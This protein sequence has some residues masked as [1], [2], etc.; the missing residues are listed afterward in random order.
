MD[1][2]LS[3]TRLD[4]LEHRKAVI[5]GLERLGLRIGRMEIF[6]ARPKE[7]VATCLEEIASC[8]LFVGI[9][10]HRYGYI[11]S[12]SHSSI[13]EQEFEC[14]QA[15]HKPTF[16][17]LLHDLY[18]WPQEFI[19]EEPGYSLLL[20]FKHRLRSSF[21][22]EEF[23]EPLDLACKVV[24]AVG[25]YLAQHPQLLGIPPQDEHDKQQREDL[26]D[27]LELRKEKIRGQIQYQRE[28]TTKVM[29]SWWSGRE[30]R[31]AAK[32][33][34]ESLDRIEALFL[35]LHERNIAA[36]RQGQLLY[37]HELT[38]DIHAL[39]WEWRW[40]ESLPR[41]DADY[42]IKVFPTTSDFQDAYPH[43][44]LTA[45]LSPPD[46]MLSNHVKRITEELNR[47]SAEDLRAL[48]PE[49][50]SDWWSEISDS[51]RRQ[52]D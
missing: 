16:C 38:S 14:A 35:N 5:N 45:G 11:P 36:I 30:K 12:G 50:L 43:A 15:H 39:L 34:L 51:L 17:F 1:I 33:W 21:V 41:L 19:E 52:L 26:V 28:R 13:T 40:Q 42:R 32:K 37:S 18:P 3:S 10:A 2:F 47:Y 8:D 48:E 29:Q 24:A 22:W 4:L 6:G 31:G 27:L 49:V 25:H 23:R 20:Q 9:Y 44:N 7:P 46:K